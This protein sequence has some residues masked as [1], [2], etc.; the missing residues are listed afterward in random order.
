MKLEGY[1]IIMGLL[2]TTIGIKYEGS[3][4][5]PFNHPTPST[6]IFLTA[7]SCH[8]LASTAEMRLQITIY[9]FHVSGIVGCQSLMWIIVPQLLYWSI[10]N[11]LLLLLAPFCFNYYELI[12]DYISATFD[13]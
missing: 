7:A 9:I 1:I 8:F 3:N 13:M 6:L 10:I 12:F 5:N 11:L 4:T 2:L